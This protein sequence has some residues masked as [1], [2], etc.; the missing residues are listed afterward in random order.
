MHSKKLS[1]YNKDAYIHLE[2]NQGAFYDV[3]IADLPD[4]RNI[5]LGRLCSHEFY[6]LCH[7]N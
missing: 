5:E 7:E 2:S 6:T 3:I 1:I 4:P